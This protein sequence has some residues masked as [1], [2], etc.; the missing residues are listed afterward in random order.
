VHVF[1]SS[2]LGSF[3]AEVTVLS[4]CIFKLQI[5]CD[6]NNYYVRKAQ[7]AA[8][9]TTER[10]AAETST[11][12]LMGCTVQSMSIEELGAKREIC[13]FCPFCV[14]RFFE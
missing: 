12:F 3:V 5:V 9:C 10:I 4:Y 13:I 2:V 7:S 1:C 11:L 6:Y 14:K 8:L